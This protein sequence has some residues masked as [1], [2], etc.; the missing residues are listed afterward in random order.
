[1]AGAADQK[2]RSFTN[3]S[4]LNTLQ[5]QCVSWKSFSSVFYLAKKTHQ[6]CQNADACPLA[7]RSGHFGGFLC[8][9]REEE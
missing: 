8:C 9:A 3:L 7:I 6:E 5:K 2:Q 1:M 4:E